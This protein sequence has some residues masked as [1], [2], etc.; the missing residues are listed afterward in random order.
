[1][2]LSFRISEMEYVR[3]AIAHVED[4]LSSKVGLCIY[5]VLAAISL[6]LTLMLTYGQIFSSQRLPAGLALILYVS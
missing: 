6:H 1:M 3:S 5:F 4:H 2:G